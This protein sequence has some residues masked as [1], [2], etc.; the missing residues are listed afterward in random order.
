MFLGLLMI[1]GHIL[2]PW[3]MDDNKVFSALFSL[4]AMKTTRNIEKFQM[5]V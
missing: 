2:V 4:F 3:K 5:F 1:S